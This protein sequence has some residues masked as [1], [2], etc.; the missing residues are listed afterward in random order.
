MVLLEQ[1]YYPGKDEMFQALS[2]FFEIKVDI[3]LATYI[4]LKIQI[5][6]V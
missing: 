1:I 4:S 5:Y 2:N 6:A 3:F